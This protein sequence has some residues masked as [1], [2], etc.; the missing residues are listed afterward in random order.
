MATDVEPPE[1]ARLLDLAERPRAANWSL[2][3]ALCR[4]AQ[5][6]PER[7]SAVLDLVRRIEFALHPHLAAVEQDGPGLWHA[8]ETGDPGGRDP[9]LLGLLR[10][11]TELDR[12]GDELATWAVDRQGARPDGDVDAVTAAV[13][14]QL[15]DL[16][17]PHEERPAR[18]PRSRG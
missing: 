6:Q 14:H 16:G 9:Y 7:V 2:R 18:P 3:A 13:A 8:L 15:A 4:Y 10:A 5:P 17:V 12:L 11:M 1:L